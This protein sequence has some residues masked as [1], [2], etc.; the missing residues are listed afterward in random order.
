VERPTQRRS[1]HYYHPDVAMVRGVL[2]ESPVLGPSAVWF[3]GPKLKPLIL[4]R[5]NS[6]SEWPQK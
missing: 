2:H 3:L 4:D 6:T 1:S 5:V